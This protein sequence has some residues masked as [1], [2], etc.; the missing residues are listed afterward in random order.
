MFYKRKEVPK[1]EKIEQ[2]LMDDLGVFTR[3]D[4]YKKMYKYDLQPEKKN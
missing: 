4:I 2:F 3:A 1:Y